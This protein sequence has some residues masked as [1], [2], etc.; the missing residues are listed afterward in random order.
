L[1]LADSSNIVKTVKVDGLIPG[2]YIYLGAITVADL[3]YKIQDP[4]P[5]SADN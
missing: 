3:E 2:S 5:T 1:V 4:N